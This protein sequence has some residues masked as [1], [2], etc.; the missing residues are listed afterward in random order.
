MATKMEWVKARK[1]KT[2]AIKEETACLLN[3][4]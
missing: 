4:Y 1:R 3:Y 2:V